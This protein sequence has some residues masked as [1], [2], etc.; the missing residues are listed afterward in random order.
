VKVPEEQKHEKENKLIEAM[1]IRFSHASAGE[2]KRILKLNLSGFEEIRAADIDH[3]YQECGRFC[4]GCAEGKMKEHA[5]IKSSKPLQSDHPGGV[6]VGDIMFIKGTKNV[7][8]PLIIHVD[9]CTKFMLGMILKDK[10][11]EECTK[12]I[13]QI[14]E[15]YARNDHELKQLVFDRE[16]GIAPTEDKLLMNGIELKLKAAG[17]KEG[18]AEVSIRLVREKARATKAEAKFQYLPPNQF[19]MDLCLDSISVLNRIPK[20]GKEKTPYEL[21]TGNQT[22]YMRDLRV[23]WGEPIVVK[24]PKEVASDLKV[25]G[26]WG[27]VVRRMMNGTGV[28]KVYLVQSKRYAYRL[29]FTRAVAPEW[30][31]ESLKELNPDMKIGFEIDSQNYE[32][33]MSEVVA[34]EENKQEDA[35]DSNFN[36]IEDE[37]QIIGGH[38]REQVILQSIQDA[39]E[40][41]N[42]MA[43]KMEVVK[44]E[45]EVIEEEKDQI[46]ENKV[47]QEMP[48][49]LYVTRSGRVS[50]PLSHLIE[51]AYAVI[52]EAYQQNLSEGCD[53]KA[54]EI[55][56]CTYSMKKALLFQKAMSSR[57]KENTSLMPP[58][59]NVRSKF[60]QEEPSIHRRVRRSSS[61]N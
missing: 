48:S 60:S 44:E 52:R 30:V 38:D 43:V 20:Q 2:L 4:S 14:K 26:P 51:T 5:R 59:T 56:E 39:E 15:A 31:L 54:K 45:E 55:V 6:T 22:N 27:V 57:P 10:S 41:W 3:W 24:K 16:P 1:H 23:E 28:L 29:H 58:L 8:R 12:A 13:L 32:E 46:A 49:G 11:E 33:E 7:K 50:R 9:V 53:N 36:D 42:K 25:T 35:Y 61:K 34:D 21:F 47:T 18:L 19:N 40:A 37:V 17:Q